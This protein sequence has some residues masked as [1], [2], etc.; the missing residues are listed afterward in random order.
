MVMITLRPAGFEPA[1]LTHRAGLILL[2]VDNRSWQKEVLLRLDREAGGRLHEEQ[3]ADG[4]LNLR[5]PLDLSPG[6]YVLTEANHPGW[7]C[8]IVITAP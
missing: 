3:L 8:R 2:A 6:R 7:S 1:E 4:K 5:M